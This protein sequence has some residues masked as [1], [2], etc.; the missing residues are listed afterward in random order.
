MKCFAQNWKDSFQ[1]CWLRRKEGGRFMREGSRHCR[2]KLKHF[3]PFRT[4]AHCDVSALFH[5][6]AHSRTQ[7]RKVMLPVFEDLAIHHNFCRKSKLDHWI[8]CLDIDNLAWLDEHW[9]LCG[10]VHAEKWNSL[11]SVTRRSRSD[12]RPLLTYSLTPLL[13]VSTDL[14]DVTLVSDDTY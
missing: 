4:S 8:E 9:T 1:I 12:S 11:F 14:T 10:S 7:R 13:S 3:L 5:H 2:L 6:V